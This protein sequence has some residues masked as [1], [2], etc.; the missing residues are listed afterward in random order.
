M[1]I[2]SKYEG[3]MTQL[4]GQQST[5]IVAICK[6]VRMTKKVISTQCGH[7]CIFILNVKFLW[8]S[9]WAGEQIK[10]KYKNGCYL[11]TVSKN[12]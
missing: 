5:N 11:K 6:S 4:A 9:F 10:E 12:D 2:H 3:S 7:M 1:Y 8:L